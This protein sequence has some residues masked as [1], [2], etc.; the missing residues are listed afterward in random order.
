MEHEYGNAQSS[1]VDAELELCLCQDVKL[2]EGVLST[3]YIGPTGIFAVANSAPDPEDLYQ[4]LRE[5]LGTARFRLYFSGK[6]LYEAHRGFVGGPLDDDGLTE[7]IT[8]WAYS[9]PALWEP[10]RQEDFA[11]RLRRADGISRG[12][13]TDE[14]GNVY[15]LKKGE[16]YPASARSTEVMFYLTLFG[17]A[18]GFHR[19][20]MGKP[21]TG[22][23]YLFTGGLFGLGWFVDLLSLFC[24]VLKDKRKC[25]FTPL[26][27]PLKKLLALPLGIA[28]TAV[29]IFM[30][31][32]VYA[33]GLAVLN[34]SVSG[35]LKQADPAVADQLRQNLD[36]FIQSMKDMISDASA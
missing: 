4:A 29:L 15:I 24:G 20:Y 27:N 7:Q 26:Q 13:Y 17:G 22:L 21:F 16:F 8:N 3:V 34:Q 36:G 25:Y 35:Q 9:E 32:S 28:F 11:H 6:G 14:E 33:G 12:Q 5:L 10:S 18:L 1:T 30:Q 2:S 23:L 31:L 19:F